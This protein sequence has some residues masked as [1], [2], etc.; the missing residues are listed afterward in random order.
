M[1]FGSVPVARAVGS[2]AAHAVRADGV[3]IRKGAVVTLADAAALARAGV[4]EMVVAELAPD[5]VPE[6]EAAHRIATALA[7]SGVR[8]DRPFTGRANLFADEAGLLLVDRA[9]VDALNAITEDVTFATLPEHAAVARDAMAATVKIIPFALPEATVAAAEAAARA[10]GPLVRI[11]PYRVTRVAAVSTLLPG[12]ATKVVDKTIATL[13][14]RLAPAGARVVG[15]LRVPHDADALARALVSLAP[16]DPELIVVFGASAIT[17]RRDVVPMAIEAVGGS[18]ERLGMPVDPGNL[19]LL[20]RIG[21]VPVVGAPGCARSPKENGFDW[22]LG[23]LLART[24]VSGAEI[25]GMG[26]GGLLMEIVSRPQ[27][28]AEA[29][30]GGGRVAGVVLA[31]GRSSRMEGPN[32]L[33]EI[34]EGR[35]LVRHA[36]E[37]ALASKALSEVVVVVGHQ[38]DRVEA[39]LAGLPV[40][41]AANP[42]FGDGLS[43]SLRAGLVALDRSVDGALVMLGDMPR[44]DPGLIGKLVA[45]FDPSSGAHAVLPTRDGKR[46]NPVLWGRRFFAELMAVEGDVGGRHVLGAYAEFVREVEADAGVLFDVDTPEALRALRAGE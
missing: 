30:E 4:S 45:A 21:N 5:D 26:V 7:G 38:A 41:F 16:A 2:V 17:D 13:E 42:A 1:R 6:N 43:T 18:V 31:A 36:V 32:K 37:A 9:G 29:E 3:T 33:L 15:E 14:R 19:L 28:R 8:V 46:G 35:P 10:S 40:R 39:A 25:A 44:I 24:P 27:L 11:A 22:V 23:R 12:L 20:G 34:V